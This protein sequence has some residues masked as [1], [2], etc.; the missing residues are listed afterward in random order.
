MAQIISVIDTADNT[1]NERY[2]M[3]MYTML[4]GDPA[5]IRA[6]LAGFDC[7][8]D[9]DQDGDDIANAYELAIGT[10]CNSDDVDD[11]IGVADPRGIPLESL[12]LNLT[13][14]STDASN[15]LAV[16]AAGASTYTQIDTGVTCNGANCDNLK[17]FIVSSG[18]VGDSAADA[19]AM[20]TGVCPLAD[21]STTSSCWVDDVVI[22][23]DGNVQTRMPLQWGFNLII[24][25]AAD[26]NGNLIPSTRQTQYIYVAPALVL[27]G[28]ATDFVLAEGGPNTITTA[29]LDV[30]FSHNPDAHD[31]DGDG[32]VQ[33]L[34]EDASQ[35][36]AIP[37]PPIDEDN[38]DF[39]GSNPYTYTV[40]VPSAPGS[41][42]VCTVFDDVLRITDV[43]EY[44]TL[45]TP[46]YAVGNPI[47]VERASTGVEVAAVRIA[48]IEVTNPSDNIVTAITSGV[49]YDYEV[50]VI[51]TN[52]SNDVIVEIT[53]MP[54][55]LSDIELPMVDGPTGNL[56]SVSGPAEEGAYISIT[57]AIGP[58][59]DAT[60]TH[61]VVYP[62]LLTG[63]PETDA[64]NDGVPDSNDAVDGPDDD[65]D[66][67]LL[68][69]STTGDDNR[70]SGWLPRCFR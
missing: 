16:G 47:T 46:F 19:V 4:S 22:D 58:I 69:S 15:T 52:R 67:I 17:A 28:G 53:V 56:P 5:L 51:P 1:N 32:S 21:S 39:T 59:A 25:V 18:S 23:D 43:V 37:T 61:T 50:S 11:Y 10:N 6:E 24:W 36:R 34:N 30:Q 49:D 40:T 55:A 42:T 41:R 63:T 35:G 29:E 12:D 54:P 57:A 60:I 45:P 14:Q 44:G 33:F 70:G 64:D 68:S 66:N 38:C 26:P 9:L 13:L 27:T 7:G 8:S 20:V 31:S 65:E 3:S 48:G 2:N 62:I